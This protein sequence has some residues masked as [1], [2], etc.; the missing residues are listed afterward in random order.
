MREK[1]PILP[2]IQVL[3][4][5]T[6]VLMSIWGRMPW[7]GTLG[8]ALL[9]CTAVLAGL[10][11][12]GAASDKAWRWGTGAAWACTLLVPAALWFTRDEGFSFEKYLD[13]Y[14]AVLA[15]IIAASILPATTRVCPEAFRTRWKIPVMAWAFAGSLLWLATAYF[16]NQARAFF[17][18]L[19]IN[20]LLL[21]LCHRWFRLPLWLAQVANTLILLAVCLPLVDLLVHPAYR[22]Q[23]R[24]DTRKRL[25][26][27]AAGKEDRAGYAT[28]W[29]CYLAEW[30]TVEKIVCVR[31]PDG[32]F[33]WRLSPN[34]HATLFQSP[35]SINSR[36]FRGPEIREPKGNTY[37]I[38]T[39]G[40]STTFGITINPEDRPWSEWLER[41]IKE[42]LQ[43]SR[44]IQVI[45]AGVPGYRLDHNLR[46][47]A[48]DILPLQPDM[49]IS[50]HGINGFCMLN[51]TLPSMV[52][53]PPTPYRQRPLGLLADVEY[54]LKLLA[55]REKRTPRL[56]RSPGTEIDPMKNPY[57]E[58]YQ[59]LI[60][61]ARTN[62]FRL[63]L[64]N[65]SMAVNK[66]SSPAVSKFYQVGYP[67]TPRLVEAN[68]LHTS[69]LRT[70]ATNNPEVYLLDTQHGLDG[71]C[72]NFLD[73]VHFSPDGDRKMA[74]VIFEGIKPL[75]ER[76]KAP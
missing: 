24:P 57:A 33:P 41:L 14:Y 23:T 38:V 39:I 63:V 43:P 16:Q 61:I 51:D 7:L 19:F 4:A 18:G 72:E 44:P 42:R 10:L 50:Y 22:L 68:V 59:Q 2:L 3:L 40:E 25:Y 29:N 12:R 67:A 62:R 45:N 8:L 6:A 54:K 73:L 1:I 28:W 35:I 32:Y 74:E 64:A 55:F 58:C 56:A 49:V 15:W 52:G 53:P 75:L 46:R 37:R 17:L 60:D 13:Q 36:G 26:S 48:A 71:K 5:G 69:M 34:S 11:P 30:D 65:F 31:S 27:Y 47:F 20:V 70:L 21:V 9:G 76:E 66:D